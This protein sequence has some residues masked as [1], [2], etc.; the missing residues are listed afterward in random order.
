MKEASSKRINGLQHIGLAVQDMDRSLQWCRKFIGLD[1]PFFDSVAGAPLMKVYTHGEVITKRASMIMNLRGGAAM[2]II[3]PTSFEP[4]VPDFQVRVGDIGIFLARIKCPDVSVAH[5]ECA[6]IGAAQP[7]SIVPDPSGNDSFYITDPDGHYFQFVPGSRWFTRG[8][9]FSGGLSGCAVGVS[10]IERSFGLYRNLLG[11][12]E[13]VY[14]KTGVFPDWK[15]LPGGEERYRRVLLTQS[16]PPGGGFARVTGQTTIELVQALD[17]TPRRIFSGRMWG[18][19][20]FVHIGF[21]VR[22]MKALEKDLSEAGFPFRCDSENVLAMG[23]TKVHCTYIDDPDGILIELIEVY[24]VPII[25]KWGI[26]LN[27][28]RRNPDRPLPNLMLKAL[29]FSRIRN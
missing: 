3:R 8:S 16:K 11:Y 12:D 6:R 20:G 2:E 29:K 4:S 25:E 28:A 9:H 14:D 27:V 18:D 24:K 26:F 1:I 21:D 5:A 23:H 19:T 17:R 22:G 15:G 13:V 7:S 10:D